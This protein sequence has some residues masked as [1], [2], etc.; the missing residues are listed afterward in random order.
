MP[1]VKKQPK[2]ERPFPPELPE[3]APES[4]D[5]VMLILDD[6]DSR[7]VREAIEVRL[8]AMNGILPDGG[9]NLE[10]R[11]IAEI[12]RG[13]LEMLRKPTR[14]KVQQELPQTA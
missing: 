1:K 3:R 13:W 10:G 12:C 9:G 5:S 11:V 4:V 7:W 8:T 6:I 2:P 14:E